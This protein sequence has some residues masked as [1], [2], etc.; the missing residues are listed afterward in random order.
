MEISEEG[1]FL[2][3]KNIFSNSY[4]VKIYYVKMQVINENNIN[5]TQYF[6]FIK[7][8]YINKTFSITYAF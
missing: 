6:V 7:S 4:K 3:K 2:L 8:Y 1:G 5:I